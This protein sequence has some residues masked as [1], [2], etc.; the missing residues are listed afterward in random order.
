MN[1]LIRYMLAM[2]DFNNKGSYFT[3]KNSLL[4]LGVDVL[5]NPR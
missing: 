4:F 2:L 5:L 3:E 1:L